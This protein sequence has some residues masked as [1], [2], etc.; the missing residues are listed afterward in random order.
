[1]TQ[2]FGFFSTETRA[3]DAPMCLALNLKLE[4]L[5]S[6]SYIEF[7]IDNP[8]EFRAE[9]I[10]LALDKRSNFIGKRRTTLVFI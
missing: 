8:R 4:L 5:T 6:R 10:S 2:S 9:I 7:G 1:M 3:G